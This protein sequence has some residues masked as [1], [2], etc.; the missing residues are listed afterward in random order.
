MK[1]LHLHTVLGYQE[2]MSPSPVD[3]AMLTNLARM[4]GTS[5]AA[6]RCDQM[7]RMTEDGPRIDRSCPAI[8]IAASTEDR[9][10][11]LQPLNDQ[12]RTAP[13]GYAG[14]LLLERRDFLF[15]QW[16][17]HDTLDF[18]T[19]VEEVIRQIWW[20]EGELKG[21]FFLRVVYEDE[22]FGYQLWYPI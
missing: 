1:L 11:M 17:H 9:T 19:M 6:F 15:Y 2:C 10:H 14:T 20:E 22:N 16:R 18:W 5:I 7:V 21:D 13:E 8:M 12:Q 4:H 3:E